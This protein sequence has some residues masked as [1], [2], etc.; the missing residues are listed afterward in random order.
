MSTKNTLPLMCYTQTENG[1]NV[2]IHYGEM[3]YRTSANA[4]LHIGIGGKKRDIDE[5]NENVGVTKEQVAVMTA[6]SMFGWNIPLVTNY[7]SQ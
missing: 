5:L 4:N 7:L 6:G 3:G 2:I 1:E